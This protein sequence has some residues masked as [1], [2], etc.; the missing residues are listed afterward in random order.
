[1]ASEDPRVGKKKGTTGSRKHVIS[2]ILQ[3]LNN[4]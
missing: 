4:Y 2:T 1:M 3:K